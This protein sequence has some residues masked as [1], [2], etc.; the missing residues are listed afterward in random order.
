MNQ[1]FEIVAKTFPG[2]EKVLYEEVKQLGFEKSKQTLRNVHFLGDWS[3]V[4]KANLFLR[5]AVKILVKIGGPFT[6]RNKNDLYN[7]VKSIN[8]NKYLSL[9]QTFAIETIGYTNNFKNTMFIN[10]RAK[11]AI[12]DQ[13]R[14]K[15]NNRPSIDRKDTDL[16]I[17]LHF[18]KDKMKIY[19]NSSGKPLFM[20]GY[21]KETGEAPLNEVIA[22]GLLLYSKWDKSSPLIDPMCGSGTIPIEASLL[23]YDI[24][25]NFYRENFAF[26]NWKNFDNNLWLNV[27][28]SI[29]FKTFNKR[30]DKK[31][32]Y[33]QDINEELIAKA[34][35]NAINYFG[36][37]KYIKFKQEDFFEWK[38]KFERATVIF[39]PPYG[40][41]LKLKEKKLFYKAMGNKIRQ[42]LV[43]YNVWIYTK[44][45]SGIEGIGIKPINKINIDNAKLKTYL[46]HFKIAQQK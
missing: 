33:A 23:A 30:I 36:L 32:I 11:D 43:N 44:E 10:Q 28:D 7:A 13:F 31:I 18:Q 42:D 25:P 5:T 46:Y 38:P 35:R 37:D 40:E 9:H 15:Y 39:N 29:T 19:L 6:V 22:A 2:L 4:Y 20:R 1:Q 3:T 34:E 45:D 17:V 24:P 16:P 14:E 26:R 27:K 12:A 8:W 41:R 21:K